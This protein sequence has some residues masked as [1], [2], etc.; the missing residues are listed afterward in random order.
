M[1]GTGHGIDAEPNDPESPTKEKCMRLPK[2][3][4]GVAAAMAVTGILGASMISS[5]TAQTAPNAV[6]DTATVAEDQSVIINV[7]ANDTP[8]GVT[9]QSVTAPSNGTAVIAS[10]AIVYTP[11]PNFHGTDTFNYT[12]TDGTATDSA[13]VTVTVTPVND[14]PVAKPDTAT[15]APGTAV[16]IDVLANDKDV[17]GDT[18]AVVLVAQPS[19]GTA[20]VVSATQKVTYTPNVGFTGTDTFT[21]YATDGALNSETVT[22]TVQV[23]DKTSDAGTK[24]AKVLAACE[25]H[26]SAGGAVK[27]LCGLYTDD[28]MPP[29]ARANFAQIILR[30]AGPSDQVMAICA[31]TNNPEKVERLCDAHAGGWLPPGLHKKLG[32]MIIDASSG[33]QTSTASASVDKPNKDHK[34]GK[35]PIWAG[36]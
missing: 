20:V 10:G 29:W 6:N 33:A 18:L 36:R 5:V 16:V 4:R 9:I 32:S 27:S 15:T 3:L 25:A 17:D 35:K 22:V 26:A 34:P 7:L 23:K 24:D 12:I 31:R 21:Y 8:A 14:A 19:N 28:S 11:K 1:G 30:M 13:T 2:R